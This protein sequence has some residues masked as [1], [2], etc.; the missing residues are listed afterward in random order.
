MAFQKKLI[1]QMIPLLWEHS[2]ACFITSIDSVF[3]VVVIMVAGV[4]I[5]KRESHGRHLC[6]MKT[7]AGMG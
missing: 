7:Q 6:F 1:K 2:I 5:V 4:I 3:I